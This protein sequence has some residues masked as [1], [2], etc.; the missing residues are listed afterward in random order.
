MRSYLISRNHAGWPLRLGTALGLI[1]A[2][3]AVAGCDECETTR[4]CPPGRICVAGQCRSTSSL[5]TSTQ[6][7][8]LVDPDGPTDT[9]PD[10]EP[11]TVSDPLPDTAMDSTPLDVD[12]EVIPDESFEEIVEDLPVFECWVHTDCN[13]SNVCTDDYCSPARFCTFI[14]ARDGMECGDD[15]FCNGIEV[16]ETGV[17]AADIAACDDGN[18]CTG[19]T[20]T[21]GSD[22]PVCSYSDAADGTSCDNGL[23]C[24][25]PDAC[26]DGDCVSGPQPCPRY[27][28]N[29]CM[30]WVCDGASSSCTEEPV[31]NGLP[32]PDGDACDGQEAC[33]D[34][35]CT[36]A[37]SGPCDDLNFCTT[38]SCVPGGSGSVSCTNTPVGDGQACGVGAICSGTGRQCLAGVCTAGVSS[39]CTD[40][41]I[42][43]WDRC[44]D[45][46]SG[47][48]SCS[49]ETAVFETVGCGDVLAG[50]Y[51]LTASAEVSSYG[52]CGSGLFGPETVLMF[53]A[54][55]APS[56]VRVTY[57]PSY[58]HG[59]ITTLL[60][61][62]ACSPATCFDSA[63]GTSPLFATP[64]A[65]FYIV[66]EGFLEGDISVSCP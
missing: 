21:E 10:T 57:A 45:D 63:A 54:A 8:T 18:P 61:T 12:P 25:G 50:I 31:A 42:C 35:A 47:S 60:L 32:C 24:D 40:G 7:D 44:V 26:H 64:G 46:G 34:G 59:T 6:D 5:D 29:P 9:I 19:A 11:E 22:G 56:S 55:S 51:T 15:L 16:C 53:S 30:H 65:T 1:L 38:D 62:D 58:A 52:G 27:H 4:D 13:D 2:L 66:I 43:T 36:D 23:F 3:P 49:S 33:T 20:C 37:A 14:P 48:P 17:C 41:D 28:D 39:P